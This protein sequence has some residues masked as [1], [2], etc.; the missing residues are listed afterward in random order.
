MWTECCIGS[1]MQTVCT[2]WTVRTYAQTNSQLNMYTSVWGSL[3]LAQWFSQLGFCWFISTRSPADMYINTHLL[4]VIYIYHSMGGH[5]QCAG[6]K[7]EHTPAT[8]TVIHTTKQQQQ[9]RYWKLAS[10]CYTKSVWQE[11]TGAI[12][13][14]GGRKEER[15]GV[16]GRGPG[17]HTIL[18]MAWQS[19]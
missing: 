9:A 5:A 19:S 15:R 16:E 1:R 11:I 3:T 8:Y 18:S 2:M 10:I 13:G 7:M 4:G 12:T 17:G 6:S 14:R